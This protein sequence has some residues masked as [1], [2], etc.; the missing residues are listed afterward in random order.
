MG[1]PPNTDLGV[2]P[3]TELPSKE[4]EVPKGLEEETRLENAFLARTGLVDC[5]ELS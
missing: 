3:K 4:D 5:E 2:C 1:V